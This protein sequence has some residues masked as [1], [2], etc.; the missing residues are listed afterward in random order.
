MKP[1]DGIET[2]LMATF[3]AGMTPPRTS[4]NRSILPSKQLDPCRIPDCGGS[5]ECAAF[6][7]A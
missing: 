4:A 3:G 5:A 6:R 7:L 2:P 1:R